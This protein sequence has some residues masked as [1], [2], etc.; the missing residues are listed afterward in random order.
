[1]VRAPRSAALL[2]LSVFL[3]GCSTLEVED[4]YRPVG[5]PP[6]YREELVEAFTSFAAD[7]RFY[8]VGLFGAPVIPTNI[9]TSDQ[10]TL[11]FSVHLRLRR[12]AAFSFASRP[13]LVAGSETLCPSA[14]AV[15]A[16]AMAQDDGTAHADGHPRWGVLPEFRYAERAPFIATGDRFSKEDLYAYHGYGGAPWELLTVHVAYTYD[17][18]GACS[19]ELTVPGDV[20]LSIDG[21]TAFDG[22]L[23]FAKA[24]RK[25]YRGMTDVQ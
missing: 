3:A 10:D 18:P 11:V 4:V 17:C 9:A 1:M 24:R 12:D 22:P 7:N 16:T 5:A 21:R 20:L 2:A 25:D 19:P 6:Q 13:C 23:R 14:V 15:D 8:S